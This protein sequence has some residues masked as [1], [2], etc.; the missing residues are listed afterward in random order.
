MTLHASLYKSCIILSAHNFQ[1]LRFLL[2][3]RSVDPRS[4]LQTKQQQSQHKPGQCQPHLTFN[5]NL[6]TQKYPGMPVRGRWLLRD[7]W[8][9]LA[10][11]RARQSTEILRSREEAACGPITG[12]VRNVCQILQERSRARLSASTKQP[13]FKYAQFPQILPYMMTESGSSK[14]V[15]SD[16]NLEI[17]TVAIFHGCQPLKMP[18]YL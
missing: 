8:T 3:D 13:I 12:F 1:N 4:F 7:S 11:R 18:Q 6:R 2:F 16:R 15:T 10:K 5:R 17:L 14:V 9:F